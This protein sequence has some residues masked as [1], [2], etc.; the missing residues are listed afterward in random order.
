MSINFYQS[1]F[2]SMNTAIILLDDDSTILYLNPSAEYLFQVSAKRFVGLSINAVFS[3]EGFALEGVEKALKVGQRYTKRKAL[4]RLPLTEVQVDYTVTPL[5]DSESKLLIE[6]DLL[7]RANQIRKEEMLVS[8]QSVAQDMIRGL[9][10]EIKNPL[11]GLR[12]AAQLLQRELTDADL[13]EYTDIIISEADRLRNLVDRLLGSYQSLNLSCINIH[14]VL[15]YT[16]KLI[17]VEAQDVAIKIDYDPSLPELMADR[18]QLLQVFLN[19][20][21][22]AVQALDGCDHPTVIL[23]T[24]IQRHFTIGNHQYPVILRVDIVDNGKG[25]DE[26]LAEKL[27][28]PMVSGRAEGTGLGLSIA[29]SIVNRHRGLI[30]FSS[31]PMKTV[32]SVYLPFGESDDSES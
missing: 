1:I 14:E 4:I 15:E 30:N 17:S 5:V 13:L 12:G 31:E 3:E 24:R 11:G 32:F 18:E 10:H 6:F 23:R 7:D 16:R 29:Q 19:L 27:F 25:I 2:D 20:V 8:S 22:N 28:F 9:A 26:H 21:R